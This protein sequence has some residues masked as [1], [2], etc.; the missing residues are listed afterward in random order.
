MSEGSTATTEKGRQ[1]LHSTISEREQVGSIDREECE[2]HEEHEEEHKECQ[3][4]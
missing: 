1:A 2:E 3:R 4:V